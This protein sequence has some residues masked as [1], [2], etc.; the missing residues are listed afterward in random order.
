MDTANTVGMLLDPNIVLEPNLD[1]D[2]SDRSNSYVRLIG[3]L[4]FLANATRPNIAYTI[5]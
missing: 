5:S 3:K 4:Q 1:G 2:A